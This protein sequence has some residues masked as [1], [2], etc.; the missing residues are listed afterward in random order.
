MT[1]IAGFRCTDGAILCADSELDYGLVKRQ[2]NKTR[3]YASIR[4]TACAA[5]TGAGDWND[6]VSVMDYVQ[7]QWGEIED[8]R[9]IGEV[10]ATKVL[11]LYERPHSDD[12][13]PVVVLCIFGKRGS[14]AQIVHV[15]D[16]GSIPVKDFACDGMGL[17]LSHYLGGTLYDESISL[18]EGLCLAAYILHVADQFAPSCGGLGNIVSINDSGSIDTELDWDIQ[19]PREVYAQ[20]IPAMRSVILG[21]ANPS[22]ARPTFNQRIA[23]FAKKLRNLRKLTE[24]DTIKRMQR[25]GHG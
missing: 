15:S 3:N 18:S 23:E 17:V 19:V 10:L 9:S 7:S 4:T 6:I 8:G 5:I 13:N 16:R 1:A 12:W 22:V 11:E 25:Y 20:L 14:K 21:V 24:L 2:V